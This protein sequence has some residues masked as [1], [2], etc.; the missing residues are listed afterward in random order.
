MNVLGYSPVASSSWLTMPERS[1]SSPY[2][3]IQ[4]SL[5]AASDS[6]GCWGPAGGCG[7]PSGSNMSRCPGWLLTRRHTHRMSPA[8][9]REKDESTGSSRGSRP[10]ASPHTSLRH[11]IPHS[12]VCNMT[13]RRCKC[14]VNDH[15]QYNTNLPIPR[16]LRQHRIRSELKW[17][18]YGYIW[19]SP[20]SPKPRLHGTQWSGLRST[21]SLVQARTLTHCKLSGTLSASG[22]IID[23]LLK[24][25][26]L[27]KNTPSME[28]C[29][30]LSIN[31]PN[32]DHSIHGIL[33][34]VVN[35]CT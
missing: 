19:L 1:G 22:T 12:S 14:K 33:L 17:R 20:T 31:A 26:N 8:R 15:V 23:G 3:K 6:G 13:W 29:S 28:Y 34:L 30:S 18:R 4:S 9:H 7:S 32:Q 16:S 5:A 24:I 27:S 11:L 2:Q 21:H 35:Q 10:S 25:K